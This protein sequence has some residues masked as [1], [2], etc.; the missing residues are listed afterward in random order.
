VFKDIKHGFLSSET[1]EALQTVHPQLLQ[2]MQQ[3]VM[4]HMEPTQIRGMNYS[5]KIA[6]SKFLGHPLDASLSPQAIMSNQTV[7]MTRN[8]SRAQSGQGKT[9]QGGLKELDLG[10]RSASETSQAESDTV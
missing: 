2:E 10:S 9:T 5:A 1:L 3:E 6:L 7:F 4:S 8:Q